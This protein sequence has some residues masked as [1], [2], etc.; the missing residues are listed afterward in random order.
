M[1]ASSLRRLLRTPRALRVVA[2]ALP[3]V[4]PAVLAAQTSSAR[5]TAA[6]PTAARTTAADDSIA[7]RLRRVASPIEL[8]R[9]RLWVEPG[10]LTDEQARRFAARFAVGVEAIERTLGRT[11]DR[12]RYGS[13]RIEVFVA[14][15]LG[16]SHVYAGYAHMR[17]DRAWL[18]LDA[19]R[20]RAGSA[21]YLHEATH[22][23]AW[24]FG[25]HSLREGLASW[26]EST[27]SAGGDGEHSQL[28][29]VRDV[30]SA[31]ALAHRAL[32]TPAGE[33]ALPTIG[34]PG[35]ADATITAGRP[36]LRAAYYVLSQS[37]VGHL[38]ER[39]G[40]PVTLQLMEADAPDAYARL[41]GQPL[42]RWRASWLAALGA[43]PAARTAAR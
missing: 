26:V 14:E 6:L 25:S 34:A 12:A 21:P 28:F 29:G 13:E 11:L 20:V 18:Y 23:V 31:D 9:V 16:A 10:A 43:G 38:V 17:H 33:L 5:P 22:L 1:P 37:F 35:P 39:L 15:D 7:A 19:A 41:T 27:V 42:E 2:I 36:E 40:L 4:V 24:R 30:A 3:L 32:A 8:T